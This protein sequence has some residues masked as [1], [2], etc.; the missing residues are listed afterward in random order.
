MQDGFTS[1]MLAASQEDSTDIIAALVEA[2]ADPNVQDRVLIFCWTVLL[3]H[4]AVQC[5][6]KAGRTALWYAAELGNASA[7]EGL[8][9]SG[10]KID[11]RDKVFY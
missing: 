5:M 2:K 11:V 1:L 10:A 8:L 7:V 3:P 4:I 9:K 6:Q